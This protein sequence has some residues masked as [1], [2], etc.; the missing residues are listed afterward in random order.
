MNKLPLIDYILGDQYTIPN[1]S[2][3]YYDESVLRLKYLTM[4]C[5]IPNKLLIP[6]INNITSK[7]YYKLQHIYRKKYNLILPKDI[8]TTLL[9]FYKQNNITI[10]KSMMV[11]GVVVQPNRITKNATIAWSKIL[12]KTSNVVLWLLE[13]NNKS[14]GDHL[15][16]F[17]FERMQQYIIN[18]IIKNM[19][20]IDPIIINNISKYYQKR[21]IIMPHEP[22][23]EHVK[24]LY[25]SV[26]LI[27]DTSPINGGSSTC[28]ALQAGVPVITRSKYNGSAV[29][30]SNLGASFLNSINNREI[31][32]FFITYNYAQYVHN[33]IKYANMDMFTL[34]KKNKIRKNI[35]MGHGTHF[36]NNNNNSKNYLFDGDWWLKNV[37]NGCIFVWNNYVKQKKI[38]DY[39]KIKNQNNIFQYIPPKYV[40]IV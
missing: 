18:I 29:I 30:Y 12:T 22:Y 34:N 7:N 33:S 5:P 13:S 20:L 17:V 28:A 11:Y 6:H 32:N 36:T 37:I 1:A 4:P 26:D 40:D 35:L 25:Y 16:K 19:N 2:L 8:P 31:I 21:I 15:N 9:T 14:H 38:F 27:L 24:R 10:H 23:N 39:K 3:K